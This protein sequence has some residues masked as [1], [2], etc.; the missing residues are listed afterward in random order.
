MVR[1]IECQTVISTNKA[2]K[3]TVISEVHNVKLSRRSCI[4]NVLSLYDSS[5][6]PPSFLLAPTVGQRRLS[7]CLPCSKLQPPLSAPH[8][9]AIA[10]SLARS[11][12]PA[13][14]S[15]D[16]DISRAHRRHPCYSQ[17]SSDPSNCPHLLSLLINRRPYP[18]LATSPTEPSPSTLASSPNPVAAALAGPLLPPPP[19][20]RTSRTHRSQTCAPLPH[21]TVLPSS[22]SAL[23]RPRCLSFPLSQLPMSEQPPTPGILNRRLLSSSSRT[24]RRRCYRRP[25]TPPPHACHCCQLPATTVAL[26]F[27]LLCFLRLLHPLL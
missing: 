11:P 15:T 12:T 13:T 6:K 5:P 7:R 14:V 19:V 18:S 16:S 10:S 26:S 23:A 24:H 8:A 3:L 2:C 1:I 27:N 17:P 22:P 4:I 21:P 20:A 9:D 25:P